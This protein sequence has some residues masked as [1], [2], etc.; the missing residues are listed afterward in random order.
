MRERTAID[1]GTATGT[2]ERKWLKSTLLSWIAFLGLGGFVTAALISS[3]SPP[4]GPQSLGETSLAISSDPDPPRLGSNRLQIRLT[5]ADDRPLS[6]ARVELT[7]G[8]EGTGLLT[9]AD[10]QRVGT[11]VYQS[12]VEFHSPG[13]WQVILT[14]KRE[15]QPDNRTTYLYNVG[16]LPGGGK[17]LVGTVRIV[18]AL[19]GKVA[20]GDALF[21]IAR[22]GPGPPLGVKRI[23][24]PSFPVSFRIGAED[25]VM[26]GGPF[27]GEVSVVARIKKG[28]VAGPA[29]AGDLEGI[30]S[31]NP[32]RIGGAPVEILIDREL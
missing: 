23:P 2:S 22:R 26:G 12:A 3:L 14:V 9:V 32:A 4:R 6:D 25:M 27:E 24:N 28:G 8:I 11:G 10:P 16:P 5:T 18:P 13:P 29:R 20:D 21:V 19:S 15:G 17:T 1:Q 30:Y 7:Y 31:R